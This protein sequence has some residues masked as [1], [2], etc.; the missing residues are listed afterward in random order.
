MM[1][2]TWRWLRRGLTL[3]M[4]LFLLVRMVP[5]DPHPARTDAPPPPANKAKHKHTNRLARETS[6]YL[7]QHAHNPV[8]WYPWGEEAFA[9]AKKEG[10]LV[11]LSVGY[12]ACHWCHVMER[13]SFE[14]E[15]IAK[16]LNRRFRLHQG[17]SRG[18]AG[19]RQRV[20]DR[21]PGHSAGQGRRLA[22]VDVPHGGRQADLRRHLLAAR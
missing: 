18:T 2:T 19:H 8:D 9:K 12:S 17:R 1:R 21:H 13:E 10:K 7:L 5:A 14:S 16:I 6:P 20:H 11:F 22:A 3:G 4:V 15:E